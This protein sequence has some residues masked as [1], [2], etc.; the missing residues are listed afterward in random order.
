MCR[1]GCAIAPAIGLRNSPDYWRL[2]P[3]ALEHAH[4][5]STFQD[6]VVFPQGAAAVDHVCL[7]PSRGSPVVSLP[8]ACQP[9]PGMGGNTES[10]FFA[11]Y[12]VD[13]G[14]LVEVQWRPDGR[15]CM[16]AVRS[17]ASDH[18]CLLTERGASDPPLLS[19]G[20]I[21]NWDTRLEVSG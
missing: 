16:K 5:H 12:Y 17:L 9:A 8:R 15:R 7:A 21:T 3:Y 4:T 11:R 20:N 1:P 13:D 18:F 19:A 6:V 2:V 14:I 10:Y